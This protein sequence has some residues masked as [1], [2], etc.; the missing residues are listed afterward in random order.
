[1]LGRRR[2]RDID[3]IFEEEAM[4]HADALYGAAMR[5]T[6]SPRDAEDLVQDALLKAY[7]HFEKYEPGTNCKAWLFRI[8]TNTFINKY[9]KR[10]REKLVFTDEDARPLA[11]R[12]AAR[13]PLELEPREEEARDAVER[14]FGDE[15][16]EALM[17]LPIDFRMVVIL[18]DVHDFSYREC[19]EILECPIGTVMSR[20]YRGRRLLR[21]QLVEYAL[22]EGVVN[23]VSEDYREQIESDRGETI[24]FP[25]QRRAVG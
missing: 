19:A 11:E 22:E 15:V 13:P 1:M 9:R 5:F 3:A 20:L 18:V 21:S 6:R 8:L 12:V 25:L 23:E 17:G 24:A 14:L 4:P 7:T 10:Q 16:S 2:R